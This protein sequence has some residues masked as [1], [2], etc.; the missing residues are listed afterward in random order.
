MAKAHLAL[1]VQQ[2]ARLAQGTNLEDMEVPTKKSEVIKAPKK[3]KP[4][5]L[6]R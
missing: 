2:I 5:D 3:V 6:Y 1:E 4:I